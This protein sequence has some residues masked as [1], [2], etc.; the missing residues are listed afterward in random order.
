MVTII[1]TTVLMSEQIVQSITSGNLAT[2]LY[3]WQ[4]EGRPS[5]VSYLQFIYGWYAMSNDVTWL[6]LALYER[7]LTDVLPVDLTPIL[8]SDTH[9][10]VRDDLSSVEGDLAEWLALCSKRQSG[11]IMES[12]MDLEYL[13]P[14]AAVIAGYTLNEEHYTELFEGLEAIERCYL[15]LGRMRRDPGTTIPGELD[16]YLP[17]MWYAAISDED[18]VLVGL[19]WMVLKNW[20]EPLRYEYPDLSSDSLSPEQSVAGLVILAATRM[21][22]NTFM[23]NYIWEKCSPDPTVG[24]AMVLQPYYMTGVNMSIIPDLPRS[25]EGYFLTKH[26]YASVKPVKWMGFSDQVDQWYLYPLTDESAAPLREEVE[27]HLALV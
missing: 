8:L 7:P 26:G 5:L 17:G 14:G 2:L 24:D 13:N 4:N 6:S 16:E 25:G 23:N 3:H 22:H 1:I 19:L 9:S 10:S 18:T 27:K 12:I 15:Y 11:G 20:R 21:Y